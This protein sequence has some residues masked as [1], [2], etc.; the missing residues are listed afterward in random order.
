[1]VEGG[2]R[3]RAEGGCGGAW[4]RQACGLAVLQPVPLVVGQPA[5]RARVVAR[6]EDLV[7]VRVRVR[8]RVRARARARVRDRVRARVRGST[9][10]AADE[11]GGGVV[12]GHGAHGGR[13][14]EAAVVQRARGA[15]PGGGDNQVTRWSALEVPCL[16][17]VITR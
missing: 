9:H 15:V 8:K 17:G 3:E 5:A 11:G 1:M 16:V 13:Q 6:V 2:R 4:S 10:H 12:V 14:V 7:R